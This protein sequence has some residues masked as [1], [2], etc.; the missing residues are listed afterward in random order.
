MKRKI[1][2][3]VSLLIAMLVLASCG[4]GGNS[5]SGSSNGGGDKA[6]TDGN[7]LVRVVEVAFGG[8]GRPFSYLDENDEIQ[9]SEADIL[10]KI[11]ELIPEYEFHFN[12]MERD[13][14]TVGLKVGKYQI[15]CGNHFWSQDRIESY[16]LTEY[17]INYSPMGLVV[18]EDSDIAS[19]DDLN[20]KSLQPIAHDDALYV[21]FQNYLAEHPGLEINCDNVA[22]GGAA[23]NYRGVVEGRWDA[24]WGP[25]AAY[26]AIKD[27]LNLPLKA[28]EPIDYMPSYFMLNKDET[29]LLEKVNAALAELTE[30]GWLGEHSAEVF[31]TNVWEAYSDVHPKYNEKDK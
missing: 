4:S 10:R 2:L 5:G 3:A 13:A 30:N 29:D 9:G 21:I 28:T 23:D 7:A 18:P 12:A 24:A 8:L 11:D 26:N 20:G 14:E 19:F 15:G 1:I 31:G 16:N 25:L 27:E 17:P 6:A 22:G